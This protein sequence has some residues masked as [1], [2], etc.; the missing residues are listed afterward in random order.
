MKI[1]KV[2]SCGNCPYLSDYDWQLPNK[3]KLYY[4]KIM[5]ESIIHPDCK[6]ENED[7]NHD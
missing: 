7:T 5:D 2:N 1:I 3:C 4:Y 6:L